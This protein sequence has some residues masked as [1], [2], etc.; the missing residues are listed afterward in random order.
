MRSCCWGVPSSR[1]GM[2]S[3]RWVSCPWPPNPQDTMS[4]A[5]PPSQI[6]RI[7]S[8]CGWPVHGYPEGLAL[9]MPLGG[10]TLRA[11]KDAFRW[12]L[13][14]HCRPPAWLHVSLPPAWTSISTSTSTRVGGHGRVCRCCAGGLTRTA[15][16]WTWWTSCCWWTLPSDTTPSRSGGR[17]RALVRAC[18]RACQHRLRGL[19]CVGV[20]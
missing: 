4:G 14:T 7:F 19:R 20:V 3:T 12:A 18:V 10:S 6:S 17:E 1:A 2:S 8:V 16:R 11:V 13:D 5:P 15:M 9:P